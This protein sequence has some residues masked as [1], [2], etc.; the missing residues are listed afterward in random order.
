MTSAASARPL[1]FEPFAQV[2]PTELRAN[3]TQDDIQNIIWAAYRQVF[4]ND[5][6]MRSE[7]LTSAESLLKQ[8]HI[9]TRDFIRALALSDLY[10]NKFFYGNPQVRFIELNFKHIL[11]RAPYD[12]SEI[13]EHVDL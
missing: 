9:T 1:G 10:K 7:R 5:H 3:S 4:G 13:S 8:G 11:G 2:T 12:Q 6:I